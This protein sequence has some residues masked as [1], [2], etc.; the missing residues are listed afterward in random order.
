MTR[1][2]V[3]INPQDLMREHLLAEHREIKRIPNTVRNG[4]A[5]VDD[6]IPEDFRLGP[7][8][9][10]FFYNKLGYLLRRYKAIRDE[11]RKRGYSITDY[12]DA[13]AGIPEH[14]MNDWVPTLEAIE[15]VQ[16]RIEERLR[17]KS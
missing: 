15:L 4:K 3:G 16:A 10:R 12:S 17:A 2:N 14:L 9:V 8:H 5:K 13:W 6:N 7:G 1:I 11:C